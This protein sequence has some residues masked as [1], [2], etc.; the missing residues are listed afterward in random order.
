M[1]ALALPKAPRTARRTSILPTVARAGRQPTAMLPV[2]WKSSR[3]CALGRE[4][5][6]ALLRDWPQFCATAWSPTR[7]RTHNA[8]LMSELRLQVR[9]P[10]SSGRRVM[11]AKGQKRTYERQVPCPSGCRVKG[12]RM[13]ERQHRLERVCQLHLTYPCRTNQIVSRVNGIFWLARLRLSRSLAKI[14]DAS[15]AAWVRLFTFNCRSIAD[16]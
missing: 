8:R 15:R 6:G 12:R 10:P 3:M 2:R 14:L 4:L 11:S 13:R 1:P 7:P 9:K 5:A 16:T